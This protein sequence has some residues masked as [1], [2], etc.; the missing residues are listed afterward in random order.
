MKW[1]GCN[2]SADFDGCV[3]TEEIVRKALEV[4]RI[5]VAS[6]NT[7]L[8]PDQVKEYVGCVFGELL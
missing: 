4:P 6:V 7:E 1:C 5:Y 8:E 3:L 2:P